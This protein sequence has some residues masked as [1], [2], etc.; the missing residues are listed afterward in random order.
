VLHEPQP[1]CSADELL[2]GLSPP[3]PDDDLWYVVEGGVDAVVERL[4]QLNAADLHNLMRDLGAA[5]QDTIK[6][7]DLPADA[8]RREAA[9][10]AS[11][12]ARPRAPPLES[13]PSAETVPSPEPKARVAPVAEMAVPQLKTSWEPELLAELELTSLVQTR[14]AVPRRAPVGSA[15]IGLALSAAMIVMVVPWSFL[16]LP[17]QPTNSTMSTASTQRVS[18]E[19]RP[20]GKDETPIHPPPVASVAKPAN[21]VSSVPPSSAAPEIPSR[22]AAHRASL[23]PRPA[24]KDETPIQP[25]SVPSVA[26]PANPASSVPPSAIPSQATAWLGPKDIEALIQLGDRFLMARDVTAARSYYERAAA[27]GSA[28]AAFALARTYDAQFLAQIGAKGVRPDA[29]RAAAWNRVATGSGS[30]QMDAHLP[31]LGSG[32]RQ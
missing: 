4:H 2:R 10:P 22:A 14:E 15:H 30:R 9:V 26:I 19:P 3:Q 18:L 28:P 20:A 13:R 32:S 16:A 29:E 7:G 24:G 5:F 8:T 31:P 25:P 11:I 17:L 1:S 23:E 6:V 21:L 27:A 12:V